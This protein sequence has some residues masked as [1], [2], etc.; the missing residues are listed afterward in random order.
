MKTLRLVGLVAV[1]FCGLYFPSSAFARPHELTVTA[2]HFGVGE[3]LSQRFVYCSFQDHLGIMWFGTRD[4]LN[5][6]DGYTFTS[7]RYQP[8]GKNNISGNVVRAIQEDINGNLWIG[9]HDGGLNYFVRAT[10]VF[11]RFR[12]IDRDASSLPSDDVSSLLIDSQRRVWIG[13]TAGVA[14]FDPLSRSFHR[15]APHLS[16]TSLVLDASGTLWVGSMEG[17]GSIDKNHGTYRPQRDLIEGTPCRNITCDHR[18]WLW[19]C[20]DR[21][22]VCYR[23]RDA[24][25]SRI[26]IPMASGIQEYDSQT[27][28]VGSNAGLVSLVVSNDS[29]TFD[30][31]T[32]I[33]TLSARKLDATGERVLSIYH[34]PDGGIW[35]GSTDGVTYISSPS[36][37]SEFIR[38]SSSKATMETDVRAI[39][40]TS[41]GEFFIGTAAGLRIRNKDGS[42]VEPAYARR[43]SG[44][45]VNAIFEDSH[46]ELW[47]GTSAHG[48]YRFSPTRNTVQNYFSEL[49]NPTSP[50][51]RNS[52][53]VWS[54]RE[55]SSGTL[56]VGTSAPA[57]I[58]NLCRFDREKNTFSF[59]LPENG[60][61]LDASVWSIDPRPDHKL[62]LATSKGLVLFDPA[63]LSIVR[64]SN[65]PTNPLTISHNE[66]W[67]LFLDRTGSCWQ[68]T[69][70]GG[71]NRLS[72][73]R[74]TFEH[75][76]SDKGIHSNII[77]AI[78]DDDR[79]VLWV[80]TSNGIFVIDPT[81]GARAP[82][83]R[84]YTTLDGLLEQEYNPNCV[85]RT[86]T[87]EIMFGGSK[88]IT[89]VRTPYVYPH[90]ASHL[91]IT[92]F[93][94]SGE[95]LREDLPDS[96]VIDLPYTSNSFT[97][98]VSALNYADPLRNIYAYKLD[99]VDDDWQY[100][101]SR[102]ELNYSHL[103]PGSYTL[104]IATGT[105]S[106]WER[107]SRTLLIRIASPFWKTPLFYVAALLMLIAG[108]L[109]LI[110]VRMRRTQIL[111]LA[112]EDARDS[113][114][115][116][117]A[118][119]LHDGPLQELYSAGFLLERLMRPDASEQ[120]EKTV[121]RL[122]S[123]IGR[124]RAAIR[125]ACGVLHPPLLD[126][127][128]EPELRRFCQSMAE[129]VTGT[130]IIL[131]QID[132]QAVLPRAF[133]RNLF[134]IFRIA[135]LNALNH[136]RCRTITI[137]LSINDRRALLEVEDDGE[138]FALPKHKPT[139]QQY[140][141]LLAKSYAR[142]VNGLFEI[143]AGLKGGT[144]V[145]YAIPITKRRVYRTF[146]R[147]RTIDKLTTHE[148]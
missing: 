65:D 99:G 117:I 115:R 90:R 43:L 10:G 75:F 138:G 23:P 34:G 17:I 124:A 87:G 52:R 9:T 143:H 66:V 112:L 73:R 120:W 1:L 122:D 146:R 5:K 95:S 125:N 128:L 123:N 84:R 121:V 147:S 91:L 142:A 134:R 16:V 31:P 111:T 127:Y 32:L 62:W 61:L 50:T 46:H 69:W 12:H 13:T 114:R 76:G 70:G 44:I 49:P 8:F 53:N 92:T 83:A 94:A 4:G 24:H 54:V 79:G 14:F 144:L 113:E 33:H 96:A 41:R 101:G 3:G 30:G 105:A 39:Y 29:M 148:S 109:L 140:G 72:E 89:V 36:S 102:Q 131:E 18:G 97:T 78:T 6:F 71:L 88:G 27:L 47:T 68:G 60:E 130:Q 141:L 38:V 145:R 137:R 77:Y 2:R 74:N 100:A 104:R 20:C 25:C 19:F 67:S 106:G 57:H 116:D 7:Y 132:E 15:V 81:D 110:R 58:T 11:Q 135:V 80:S 64:Y 85:L 35:V 63:T 22:L 103:S 107:G 129:N 42:F 136:A 118:S 126:G 55:D 86:R 37:T 133:A 26:P 40:E 28:I 21:Y 98:T 48:L 93:R 45:A 51:S 139:G 119:D 108:T 82:M 59:P 56:W